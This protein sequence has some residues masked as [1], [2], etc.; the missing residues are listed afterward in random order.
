MVEIATM[1]AIAVGLSTMLI[2]MIVSTCDTP[3]PRYS[4]TQ[5]SYYHDDGY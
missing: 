3:T 5:D 4:S 1:F 2:H